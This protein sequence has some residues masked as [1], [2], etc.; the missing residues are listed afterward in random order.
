MHG[1]PKGVVGALP[2]SAASIQL[3]LVAQWLASLQSIESS[4]NLGDNSWIA[5]LRQV[6]TRDTSSWQNRFDECSAALK[7]LTEG[8]LSA[9]VKVIVEGRSEAEARRDV[10]RLAEHYAAGGQ[11]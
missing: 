6:L 10:V 3:S 2:G 1:Q 8:V 4:S 7:P 9:T 5:A 11:R